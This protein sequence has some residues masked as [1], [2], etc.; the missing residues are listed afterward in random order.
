MAENGKKDGMPAPMT[1]TLPI[2]SVSVSISL[3]EEIDTI[4]ED[5]ADDLKN[6]TDDVAFKLKEAERK[7]HTPATQNS[8]LKKNISSL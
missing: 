2:T 4:I 8:E 3:E 5:K 6:G 1:Q 7:D